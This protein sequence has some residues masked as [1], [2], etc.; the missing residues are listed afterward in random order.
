MQICISHAVWNKKKNKFKQTISMNID[1]QCRITVW[2]WE[3][4]L[5]WKKC[6]VW[7]WRCVYDWFPFSRYFDFDFAYLA[8]ETLESIIND[9]DQGAW[10]RSG[11]GRSS[12]FHLGPISHEHEITTLLYFHSTIDRWPYKFQPSMIPSSKSHK[13]RLDIFLN[14]YFL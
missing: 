6:N 4:Y 8:I 9:S 14:C 13:N 12:R 11:F 3:C 10:G 1:R 2:Q 7:Y 5:S